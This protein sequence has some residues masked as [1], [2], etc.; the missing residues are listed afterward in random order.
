VPHAYRQTGGKGSH[1]RDTDVVTTRLGEGMSTRLDGHRS[2]PSVALVDDDA[3]AVEMY[4]LGLEASGFEVDVF[5]D[6]SAFFRALD[7]RIPDVAV[8]DW[9]LQS[10]LTGVDILENLRL[11]E[12]TSHLPVVML[13][14]HDAADGAHDRAMKAGARGWLIKAHTTPAQ[15]ARRLDLILGRVNS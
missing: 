13:S 1:F 3:A 10:I 2:R 12:R 8:L 15:L 7:A 4:R 6:G 9:R 11:D 5:P 14:N